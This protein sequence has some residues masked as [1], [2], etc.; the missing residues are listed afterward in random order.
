MSTYSQRTLHYT[1]KRCELHWDVPQCMGLSLLLM[2]CSLPSRQLLSRVP[3][4]AHRGGH[5][6]KR[7]LRKRRDAANP[8]WKRG[9]TLHV[10]C[11]S[12]TILRLER[13]PRTPTAQEI[14]DAM[15]KC[16]PGV[17]LGLASGLGC[18]DRG[19]GSTPLPRPCSPSGRGFA[20]A[21]PSDQGARHLRHV[22]DTHAHTAWQGPGEGRGVQL[23]GAT[24]PSVRAR[25]RG[26][27]VTHGRPG[28]WSAQGSPG[29]RGGQSARVVASHRGRAG[30][31]P[32]VSC[33]S[34]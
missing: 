5:C 17:L 30:D 10:Q 7:W 31:R 8:S 27:T 25:C 23:A 32:A 9:Q 26:V 29:R 14:T 15:H 11:V 12:S 1:S 3:H 4:L 13:A 6:L 21:G 28:A 2:C 33:Y 16:A 20:R 34:P 19:G 22:C 24:V 18:G